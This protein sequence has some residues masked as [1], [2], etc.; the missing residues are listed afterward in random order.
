M[1]RNR[2]EL[3]WSEATAHTVQSLQA[4][5][6]NSG[7][8]LLNNALTLYEWYAK[9]IAAGR[10]VGSLSADHELFKQVKLVK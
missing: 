6:N 5:A 2:I 1:K 9:E 3:E 7:A 8:E 10:M 4:L